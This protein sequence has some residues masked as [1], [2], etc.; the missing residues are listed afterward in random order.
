MANTKKAP[1][2]QRKVT[3]AVPVTINERKQFKKLAKSRRQ[4]L[5]EL[6]RQELY[7]AADFER[8]KQAQQNA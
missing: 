8:M 3:L 6:V 7:R 5:S 1:N 4:T 2:E